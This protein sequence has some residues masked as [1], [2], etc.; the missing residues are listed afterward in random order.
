MR[1]RPGTRHRSST[2]R[3][4]PTTTDADVVARIDTLRRAEKWSAS[5]ISFELQ[6]EG[7]SIS[8]R[9]VSRR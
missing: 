2:P 1:T 9:T 8:R 3:R 5:R 7:V 4:Q 6:A